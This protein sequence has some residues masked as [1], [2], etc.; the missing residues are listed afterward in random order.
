MELDWTKISETVVYGVLTVLI[1]IVFPILR[2]ML[3]E[4]LDQYKSDSAWNTGG[5]LKSVIREAILAT[6]QTLVNDLR[7]TGKLSEDDRNIALNR[8]AETA[9]NLIG[10]SRWNS[11]VKQLGGQDALTNQVKILIESNLQVLKS[12][13]LIV[14]PTPMKVA[15]ARPSRAKK[16]IDA[17]T[18]KKVID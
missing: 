3:L 7:R 13:N 18:Q 9:K 14:A 6:E 16:K 10:D 12:E 8:A 15:R 2:K 5:L 1:T 4:K 17:A 11:L